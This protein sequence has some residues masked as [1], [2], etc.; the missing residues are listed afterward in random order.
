M[1]DDVGDESER[2]LQGES[3]TNMIKIHGIKFSKINKIYSK[4]KYTG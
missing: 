1:G 4:K 3:G 2:N